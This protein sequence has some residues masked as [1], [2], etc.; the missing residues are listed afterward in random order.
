MSKLFHPRFTTLLLIV[1]FLLG[2]GT[3]GYMVIE[4]WNWLDALYMTVIGLSTVGFGEVY[5]LSP[6]GRFFT[7]AL[8]VLG[9][10]F[11]VYGL[12]YLMAARL[13][14]LFRRRRDMNKIAQ[15]QNHVIVCGYGRVGQSVV[16]LLR[17]GGQELV[18]IEND[19]VHTARLEKMGL[20]FVEGDA[21]QDEVLEQAGLLRARGLIACAGND[22]VNLFIV[23][24]ARALHP[25]LYIVAR[26][27]DAN[28]ESKIK[29]AGA[30]RVVSLYD[31]SGRRM[32]NMMLRP[33][34][35]Q[36]FDGVTLDNGVKLWVEEIVIRAGAPLA[37]QTVGEADVRRKT[38]VMLVGLIRG[39][40]N[41][42][43][44]AGADTRLQAGVCSG[45]QDL[46]LPPANQSHQHNA[47]FAPHVCFAH[48]LPGQWRARP[49]DDLFNPQFYPVVQRHPVEKLGSIRPQHHVRHAPAANIIQ[50]HHPVC[51]GQFYLAFIIGVNTAGYDIQL[52]VKGARR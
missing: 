52:R 2:L 51:A 9:L 11:I 36:F 25:E 44:L 40:Q 14:V 23:L 50:R 47:G 18:I 37:G 48:G 5:P 34:A 15:L 27:I 33:Y 30:D 42:V 3:A 49:D 12:D 28:N 41:E 13:D 16:D 39:G 7:I 35:T 29:L 20:L 46:V 24:S 21:T 45:Q 26:S 22:S 43:L 38:G 32:A 8:I 17:A 6:A 31:I 10:G 1:L 4:G 19:P